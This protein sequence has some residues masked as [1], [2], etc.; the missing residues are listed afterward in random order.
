MLR[1]AR[2][3]QLQL[4]D[5]RMVL[6]SG[7]PAYSDTVVIGGGTAGAAVAGTL[8]GQSDQSVLLLEAG[9]DYGSFESGNWPSDLL[10][11][12]DLADSHGWGYESGD[13]Y[14]GRT[15]PFQRARVIGGC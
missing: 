2:V 12:F 3:E 4:Q 10:E 14:P 9:P 11:A 8:A 5:E 6:M 15:I 7:I 1:C 13:R